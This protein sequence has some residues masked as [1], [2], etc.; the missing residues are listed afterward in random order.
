MV[1]DGTASMMAHNI[2]QLARACTETC[3]EVRQ[4][5]A[6]GVLDISKRRVVHAEPLSPGLFNYNTT[7]SV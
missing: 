7:E 4:S 3:L 1:K 2:P 5:A 6:K